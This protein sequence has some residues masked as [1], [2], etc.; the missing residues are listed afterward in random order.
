MAGLE[1]MTMQGDVKTASNHV[2]VL[3]CLRDVNL[4]A[5]LLQLSLLS[6]RRKAGYKGDIVVFT[7]FSRRLRDEEDLLIRRVHVDRYPSED[8]R[9]FRIYMD[10]YY[11]F[12]RHRK[13]IYMDFDVLAMKN[14][15][16]AFG[17][18]RDS[19]VYFTYAPV[20]KWSDSAFMA[21]AYIDQYRETSV[22]KGSVTGIC[23]GIFGVKTST[24]PGF[25]RLWREVLARTPTDNDQHALNEMIVRGMIEGH[26]YPNEWISY[27]VQVRN[28]VNDCRVFQGRID[29]LFC[30]FNPTDNQTKYQMMLHYMK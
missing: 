19:A 24:L 15:N 17:Y 16:R 3:V 11:D 18:I 9:N 14:I 27:P 28:E 6:L 8:P 29:P 5:E 26:A 13:L 22:V 30:H 21:G 10:E 2:I 20:F 23:S 25:L 1:Y 12:S 4:N 7:D